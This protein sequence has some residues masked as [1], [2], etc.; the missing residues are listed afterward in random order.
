MNTVR[1]TDDELALTRH[2]LE[3]YLAAFGHDEADTVARIRQVVEKFRAPL[4][5][6]EDP[7][8]IA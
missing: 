4:P 6:G 2:A 3:A 5:E 1:L 8:H 7:R